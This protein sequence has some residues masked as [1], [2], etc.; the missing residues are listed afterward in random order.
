MQIN[1][2]WLAALFSVFVLAACAS[3][4]GAAASDE[5]GG[6]EVKVG[7]LGSICGGPE[8]IQCADEKAYCA[9]AL[10][11][12]VDQ[13]EAKGVCSIRPEICTMQYLPVCGCDGETYPNDCAAASAGVN[14]AY[15]GVCNS[16]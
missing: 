5:E 15:E 14:V 4:E 9:L 2:S 12:C 16:R 1:R 8:N 11:R 6:Q 7:A 10:G 13:S 3:D